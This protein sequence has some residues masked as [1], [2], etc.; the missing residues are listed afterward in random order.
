[1]SVLDL[2]VALL[3]L[4]YGLLGY[5]SGLARRVLGL[6]LIILAAEV[7]TQGGQPGGVIL[8]Q[9]WPDLNLPD[10]RA[11]SWLLIFVLITALVEVLMF[12]V[13][14]RLKVTVVAFDKLTGVLVGL[15]SAVALTVI[16]VVMLGGLANPIGGSTQ[17]DQTQLW[18]RS[19]LDD[20]GPAYALGERLGP[21]LGLLVKA[22]LPQD[23]GIYFG[24]S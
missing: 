20:S 3:F 2:V 12:L 24:V 22:A 13:R 16:A 18:A 9:A 19:T 11:L 7:A 17:M 8:R 14:D 23:P 1:M 5:W 4:G 10:A 15:L 21:N 6:I